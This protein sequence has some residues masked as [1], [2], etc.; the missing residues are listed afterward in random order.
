MFTCLKTDIDELLNC[1]LRSD[2][3][4]TEWGS[5]PLFKLLCSE[6]DSRQCKID[7]YN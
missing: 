4:V 7:S 2:A 6:I 5:D 3:S 1:F